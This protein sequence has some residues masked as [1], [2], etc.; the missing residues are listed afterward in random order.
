MMGH[1]H[2]CGEQ[3]AFSKMERRSMGGGRSLECWVVRVV[4][5]GTTAEGKMALR[6]SIVNNS[7]SNNNKTVK[8][9]ISKKVRR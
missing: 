3:Q 6:G 9:K 7:S 4:Q 2:C 5:V 8:K 1:D